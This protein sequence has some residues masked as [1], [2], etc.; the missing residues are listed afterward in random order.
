[1]RRRLPLLMAVLVLLAGG[2]Y[3]A[4]WFHVARGLEDGVP[5]WAAEQRAAGYDLTWRA[6]SVEGFPLAV[7]LRFAAPVLAAAR[8]FPYR[9]RGP[10]L[11]ASTSPFDLRTWRVA[12]PQGMA[13]EAPDALASLEAQALTGEVAL[14]GDATTIT[15]AARGLDGHGFARSL[16]AEALEAR[17]SLPAHA[18]DG[19]RAG[20]LS[21]QASLRRVTL[22]DIPAPLS[23]EVDTLSVAATVRGPWPAGGLQQALVRWRDAG[24]TVELE[25]LHAAWNG[26][27][28]D[29]GGTLALDAAMQPEGA[30][31]A[32][33]AGADKAVDAAVAAGALAPRYAGF[34]KTV[35]RAISDKDESGG[36]ALTMP[37]TIQDQRLYV[38]PAEVAV[39]PHIGWQ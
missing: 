27:T 38:G 11:L 10:E 5:A 39:L 28:L 3:A 2:A 25:S 19:G 17:L 33:I 7:R 24:G 13:L 1:M 18:H 37:L 31:T 6:F 21:L 35:L 20:V 8:P 16:S 34:A 22:P 29:A 12:A 9:A 4:Y 26:T 14:G 30:M 32:R 36:D 23:R 15:L